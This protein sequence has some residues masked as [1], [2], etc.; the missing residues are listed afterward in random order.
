[1]WLNLCHRIHYWKIR[2]T[3]CNYDILAC[4]LLVMF[5]TGYG[6]CAGMFECKSHRN[7]YHLCLGKTINSWVYILETTE[8]LIARWTIKWATRW[9]ICWILNVNILVQKVK[10]SI[11]NFGEDCI[12]NMLVLV[13]VFVWNKNLYQELTLC[14]KANFSKAHLNGGEHFICNKAHLILD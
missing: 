8:N 12:E 6:W 11:E 5:S 7:I 9:T 1:M 14:T 4:L 3:W 10:S 13:L 2:F